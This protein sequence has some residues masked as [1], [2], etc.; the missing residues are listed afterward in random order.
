[1]N[2]DDTPEEAQ[3]RS[4]VRAWLDANAIRKDADTTRSRSF[5]DPQEALKEAKAW[6]EKYDV[7]S[8]NPGE[9]APDF[10]LTDTSGNH[11]IRLSDFQGQKPVALIFGSFS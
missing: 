10:S 3:Y 11:T 6:Q 7:N 2:F 4:E 1:M 8:P 9:Q 5:G